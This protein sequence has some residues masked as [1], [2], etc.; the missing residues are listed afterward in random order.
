MDTVNQDAQDIIGGT[1]K[2]QRRKMA[3]TARASSPE[4]GTMTSHF[5]N[6]KPPDNT[7]DFPGFQVKDKLDDK[8]ILTVRD[9][10]EFMKELKKMY[11][12]QGTTLHPKLEEKIRN[13]VSE[14]GRT[15]SSRDGVPGLDAEVQAVNARLDQLTKDGVEITDEVFA[16]IQVATYRVTPNPADLEGKPFPACHNCTNILQ[17]TNI[18]TGVIEE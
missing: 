3:A 4:A 13:Y 18:L 10:N 5:E 9:P 15:F 2:R 17:G 16:Q 8:L 1:G 7:E 14:E 12:E 11:T 6:I